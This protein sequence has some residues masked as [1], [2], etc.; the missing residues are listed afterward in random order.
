MRVVAPGRGGL[1]A[2]QRRQN[3]LAQALVTLGHDVLDLDATGLGMSIRQA[4]PVDQ[5]AAGAQDVRDDLLEA[6]AEHQLAHLIR[7]LLD[8]GQY[9]NGESLRHDRAK[10]V[11]PATDGD[12]LA[13]GTSVYES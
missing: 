12:T 7:E 2:Q 11:L 13:H 9:P 1:D 8:A 3:P 5:V 6:E 4:H 10:R